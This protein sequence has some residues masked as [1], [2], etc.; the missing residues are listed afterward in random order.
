MLQLLRPL[1]DLDGFPSVLVEEVVWTHAQH[2]LFLLENYY[3]THYTC[4]YQPVLQ[5]FAIS[6]ICDLVARFFPTKSTNDIRTKDGPE[7]ITLGL[8]VLQDSLVGF[9]AAGA[10]HELLR[11]AAVGCSVRLPHSLDHLMAPPRSPC[12]TYSYED[13]I[14]VCTR[15]SYHQPVWSVREKFDK[16]LAEDWYNQSPEYGFKAPEPGERSLRGLQNE[17]DR[18]VQYLMQ[19]T[20]LLNRN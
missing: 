5:M 20:N 2:A 14:N 18:G 15:P 10:I 8:E 3:R 13:F 4:R 16:K 11:R 7:A 17:P 19:I 6:S 9:P 1:I 12:P